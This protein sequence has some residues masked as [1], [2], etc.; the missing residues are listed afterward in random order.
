MSIDLNTAEEQREGCGKGPVPPESIVMLQ[1]IVRQPRSGKEGSDQFLT[2][3]QSGLEYLDCEFIVAQGSYKDQKFWG[4]LNVSGATT[5]GQRKACDISMRTIRAIVESSRGI[6]PKDASPQAAQGR[7]LQEWSEL[8]GIFFPA[9]LDAVVGDPDKNGKRWVNNM[10]KKV[11]TPDRTEEYAHICNGGE[12]ISDKP[13][14]SVENAPQSAKPNWAA[15]TT[16]QAPSPAPATAQQTVTPPPTAP[17]N[18]AAPR[19]APQWAQTPPPAAPPRPDGA[20]F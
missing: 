18:S 13:L 2:R 12:I 3:A 16:A 11:V 9:M 1:M 6:H 10:L 4:N 17:Q 15:P 5:E 8:N 14:P 7:I 19:P 20:P